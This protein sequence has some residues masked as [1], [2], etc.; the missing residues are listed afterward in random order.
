M[1]STQDA[2]PRLWLVRHARP[3]IDP[4]LCYGRLDVSADPDASRNAAMALAHA[5]PARVAAVRHSPLRRC[6]QLAF[7]LQRLRPDL[8]SIPEPRIA[9]LDFGTWEGRAWDA[10]PHAEI[11]AWSARLHEHA[12]GGGESLARMLARVAQALQEAARLAHADAGAYAPARDV[13]WITHAGVARCVHWLCTHGPDAVPTAAQWPV[14]A[15]ACG[16]WT[17]QALPPPALTGSAAASAE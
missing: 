3:Q 2:L 5:L 8:T 14:E 9:E 10:L 6:E 15:P 4:G 17:T 1:P 13:V 16:A 11:D 7:H 12:P